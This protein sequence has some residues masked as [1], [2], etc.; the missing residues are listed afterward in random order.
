MVSWSL[1]V[2]TSPILQRVLRAKELFA[3]DMSM[4]EL[5]CATSVPKTRIESQTDIALSQ[6][7]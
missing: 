3:N 4:I 1:A 5:A 6:F 7:F 2:N